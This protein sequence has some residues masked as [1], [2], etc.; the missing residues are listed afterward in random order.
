MRSSNFAE[1]WRRDAPLLLRAS[2]RTSGLWRARLAQSVGKLAVDAAIFLFGE[3]ASARIS[4]SDKSLNLFSTR[5]A[6]T[7]E[8]H[9]FIRHRLDS[10]A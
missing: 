4:F 3:I 8:S 2:L 10:V 6:W 5:F 9:T 7:R 1:T